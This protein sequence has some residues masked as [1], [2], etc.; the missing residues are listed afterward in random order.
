VQINEYRFLFQHIRSDSN[1]TAMAIGFTAF[2]ALWFFNTLRRVSYK[3]REGG[4][5]EEIRFRK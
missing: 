1:S 2:F 4:R 3:G 5:E